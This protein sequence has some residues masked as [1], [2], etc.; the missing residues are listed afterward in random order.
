MKKGDEVEDENDDGVVRTGV[1]EDRVKATLCTEE[2][3]LCTQY[4]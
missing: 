4:K 1:S 2:L 3:F